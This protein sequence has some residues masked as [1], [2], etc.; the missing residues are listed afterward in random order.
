MFYKIGYVLG[1]IVSAFLL[2]IAA[3]PRITCGN[4]SKHR[5]NITGIQMASLNTLLIQFQHSAHRLPTTSEGLTAL[6]FRPADIPEA[7][8]RGPFIDGIPKDGW[9]HPFNYTLS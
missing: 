4:D 1:F 7:N 2:C 5:T 8:W 3:G 9:H 6:M